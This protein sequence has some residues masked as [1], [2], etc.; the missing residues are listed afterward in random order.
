MVDFFISYTHVDSRWAEWIAYVLE[1][2][3]YSTIIQAWDF[4]PG[5]NFV[6]EM[7]RAAAKAERTIMVLSPA[8]LNSEMAAPEWASAFARDPQGLARRLVPVMVESCTP[9]GLLPTIVQIRIAGQDEATARSTLV[10]GINDAR[11]KPSS[12]P[13]FPGG[14]LEHKPFP[15]PETAPPS[16]PVLPRLARKPTD[17][18]R[19]RFI[20]TSFETIRQTFE[21]R[22]GQASAESARVETDFTARSDIDFQAELYLDGKSTCQC[23]IWLGNMFGPDGIC[24]NEGR[25]T[26]DAC[27]EVIGVADGDDLVLS[28]M[29]AMDFSGQEPDRD[30]KRMTPENAASY[31]WDRFVR[32]LST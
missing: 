6:L 25:T 19:R 1:E 15:G 26:G 10:A 29:M 20:K 12:R 16:R 23:R 4:R 18:D 14:S 24:F 32:R 28:A 2:E 31:L 5:S 13:A 8:Y 7:Q 22:L 9:E 3:G 17:A 21:Q 11:A 30:L 27:N